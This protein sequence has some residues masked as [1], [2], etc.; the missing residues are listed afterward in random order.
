MTKIFLTI[1]ILLLI[2]SQQSFAS[3]QVITAKHGM[4]V[5]EQKLASKVGADILR[6]GGNAID[7]AIA[8]G[9][10]LA[11]VDPCCGNL[12]G[13]GFM[14][15]HLANG[16]NIFV[17]FRETA[18]SK[19]TKNMFLNPSNNKTEISTTGY[20]AVAIPGTVLGLDT[21]LQKYGTMTRKQ[22]MTP[23]IHLAQQGYILTPY[24]IK[25]FNLLVNDFR[26]QK[27]VAAI[28]LKNNHPYQVGDRLVQND[29]AN[30]LQ[31]I[32]DKGPD[33]F[34]KGYIAQEIVKASQNHGG[35]LT[36]KD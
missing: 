6:K 23:A 26:Q 36:L 31:R 5:S 19:A 14:T 27:N 1:Y 34:Y 11:V 2:S 28:F 13:G 24:D 25:L 33:V 15:I 20:L 35:I 9:Y 3:Q 10:A 4:V 18:G 16:K 17:N 29:L 21:V 7:A 12:G 30:T 8:V 22:V 32:A